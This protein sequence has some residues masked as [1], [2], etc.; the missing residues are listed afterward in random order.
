MVGSREELRDR[1]IDAFAARDEIYRICLFGRE[2]ARRQDAYSD[3]DI[4]VYSGDPARTRAEYAGVLA[5]IS[6]IRA[7]FPLGGT[8]EW[9]S[10]MVMLRDYNPYHKVDFSIGGKEDWPRVTV[11]D[12]PEKPQLSVS[13]LREVTL[14]DDVVR[15]LTDVLFSVPRFTKCLFRRDVDMYRRWE[16]ITDLAL[17]L[18]YERHF[19]WQPELPSRRLAL[20]ET[21]CL[22]EVL[23]PEE[24][25]DLDHIRPTG[26]RLDLALSYQAAVKLIVALS[27]QKACA[28][29]KPLD[30]CF[31]HTMVAFLDAEIARYLALRTPPAD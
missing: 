24:V 9:Y 26:G 4:I 23:D 1:L 31:T 16:S 6:P 17:V 30:P 8:P 27:E 7:T 12:D 2:V 21:Q 11:Y 28:Q 18:L 19:G 15:K 20:Y 22:L 29:H 5:G 10:E 25:V 13:V 14:H 3:I